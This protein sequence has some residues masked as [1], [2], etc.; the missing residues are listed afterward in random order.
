MI[1]A[2]S[3]IEV[4]L[5]ANLGITPVLIAA[6]RGGHVH[7]YP[8]YLGTIYS[9]KLKK[10][11]RVGAEQMLRI[12]QREMSNN[13]QMKVFKPYGFNNTYVMGMLRT[14]AEELGIEKISDLAK[15]PDLIAGFDIEFIE[16]KGDGMKDMFAFYGFEP[17]NPIVHL[18]FDEKYP[19]LAEGK[20]GY[21]DPFSTDAKLKYFDIKFLEDDKEFFPP[22]HCLTVVREDSLEQ[23]PE[24][25]PIL[26]GLENIVN[27]EE[28]MQLN[29]EV[30][31]NNREPKEVAIEFLTTKG[32][33]GGKQR[34]IH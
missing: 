21:T 11:E 2:Q 4:E 14:R 5:K 34:F 16:R 13:Y 24:L 31:E 6:M 25:G 32:W 12:V 10:T 20:V 30:E 7:V 17:T 27:D 15:H 9:M 23:F 22:Y 3:D 1:R 26:S 28:A 8:E 19:A 33:I 29:F 18:E